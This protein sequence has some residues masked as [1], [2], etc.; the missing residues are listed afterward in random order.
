MSLILSTSTRA[1]SPLILVF[2]I[3]IML[4]GHHLPGGGFIGG[5]VAGGAF[6]LVMVSEGVHVARKAVSVAPHVLVASGLFIALAAGIIGLV[7]T[8]AFLAGIWW[9]WPIPLL[10]DVKVGT[11]LFFDIGVYLLVAGM[12]V[13]IL[14]TLA[15]ET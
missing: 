1:L 3:F 15:E 4:R 5:M 14:F 9:E 8:G 10:G 11:P 2:S 7:Q 13:M 6:A 12:T